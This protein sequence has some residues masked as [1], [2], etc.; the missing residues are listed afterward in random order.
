MLLCYEINRCFSV[1]ITRCE[2]YFGSSQTEEC[3]I[4]RNIGIILYF[5]ILLQ[6]SEISQLLKVI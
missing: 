5:S 2:I 1:F 6:Y 3:V 4:L